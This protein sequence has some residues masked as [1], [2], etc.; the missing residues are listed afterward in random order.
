MKKNITFKKA[1]PFL[2]S[3]ALIGMIFGSAVTIAYYSDSTEALENSFEA[4]EITTVIIEDNVNTN[5]ASGAI[6]NKNPKIKN[7]GP[8]TGFI[9]A[10]ITV[11]PDILI[12]SPSKQT[13]ITDDKCI[14]L[15]IDKGNLDYAL[16]LDTN[17]LY[18]HDNIGGWIYGGDGYYYY[19]HVVKA[20]N[21]TQTLFDYVVIGT[22]VE[23]NFDVTIYQEAITSKH[24]V[25]S[26]NEVGQVAISIMKQ[27]FLDIN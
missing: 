20:G 6:V 12:N 26:E 18:S 14:T 17:A 27:A 8:A 1:R 9:R 5:S 22:A 11:S 23:D 13:G 10:R 4:T 25:S 16:A 24:Y 21:F 7:E 19:N 15:M 2:L 3:A